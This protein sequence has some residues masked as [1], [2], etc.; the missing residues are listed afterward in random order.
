MTQK[1]TPKHKPESNPKNKQVTS[2]VANE[3]SLD[4]SDFQSKVLDPYMAGK[5]DQALQGDA[6]MARSILP[7]STAQKRSFASL[8]FEYPA[9]EASKCVACMEC[10]IECPDAAI[11]AR[12]TPEKERGDC[13]AAIA[14]T[15]RQAG[16]GQ[17]FAK[18]QKFWEAMEKKQ[19]PPGHFSIWVDPDKCKGCGEC[20]AIC[21][22]H[23]ALVMKHKDEVDMDAERDSF[24]F[25]REKLPATPTNFINDKL[26]VDLFLLD[27]H[28]VYRG[29]AGA[30]KGCGEITAL[31]MALTAT[32]AKYGSNMAIVAATGCNSVFSSTYPYNIFSVPW[33]NPLF[34]NAPA[35][36]IGVRMRLNQTGKKDTKLWVVGGDGAMGDIGFQSLSR[37]LMS[38]EDIKVLVMDTQVYSNTGGQA[39]GSTFQGQNAK[40]S[41]CGLSNNGKSEHRK[42]LGLILMTHPDAYIAQVSPAYYNHFLRAVLGALEYPGP[43]VILAYSP[44]MPE[45]GIGDDA[46]FAQ[47]HAAVTSRAY[48]IYIYD[49]RAGK[50]IKERL[51]LRG[52]PSISEAWHTDAKTGELRDFVWFARKEERF[53][54]LFGKDGAPTDDLLK[55]KDDRNRNWSILKEL[56]GMTTQPSAQ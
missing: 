49:P 2:K 55:A 20:A 15:G 31:K 33:T 3:K 51:D 11:Y 48:P 37:M 45:H 6:A 4:L 13:V 14:D 1:K 30:C 39:S 50:T 25:M 32:S 43:A 27:D 10:V 54:K 44:C 29:G 8:V 56:A 46:A 24:R 26:L 36:A 28:W 7:P 38:G 40:M 35:T 9:F 19:K 17:R 12:V 41:A 53:A 5:A 16:I 42:E 52:N 18:T 34:E 22:E 21:H 47:S 23:G